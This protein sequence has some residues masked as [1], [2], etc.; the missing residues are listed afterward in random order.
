MHLG[1]G[2]GWGSSGGHSRCP[3]CSTQKS[4]VVGLAVVGE[5]MADSTGR[6]LA[7]NRGPAA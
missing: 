3:G 6:G 4:A 2:R 7:A 5:L 1:G